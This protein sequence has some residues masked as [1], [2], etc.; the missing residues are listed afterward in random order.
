MPFHK[1]M[2]CLGLLLCVLSCII[3]TSATA[4]FFNN[5]NHELCYELYRVKD[6]LSEY[7]VYLVIEEENFTQKDSLML[8]QWPGLSQFARQSITQRWAIEGRR[9]ESERQPYFSSPPVF[10]KKK[11]FIVPKKVD[12]KVDWEN[13]PWKDHKEFWAYPD[14]PF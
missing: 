5:V 13:T 9:I 2:P 4:Q 1:S 8:N 14:R 7:R 11:R 3:S 6:P 12:Q 10:P